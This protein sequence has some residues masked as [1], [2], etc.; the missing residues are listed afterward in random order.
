MIYT[1]SNPTTGLDVV[2]MPLFG[3]GTPVTLAASSMNEYLSSISDD[4]RWVTISD[5]QGGS[6]VIRRLITN[7]QPP[8]GGTFSLGSDIANRRFSAVMAV[9]CSS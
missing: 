5:L 4:G 1:V 6:S 9:K 3:S 7:G 8:L 2:A